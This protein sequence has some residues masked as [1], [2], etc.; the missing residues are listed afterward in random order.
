A[1]K[2]SPDTVHAEIGEI[3]AGRKPGRPSDEETILFW[4]RGLAT[5][6]IALGAAILEKAARLK[7]GTSLVYR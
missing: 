7:I 6:D 2:V 4:H 5:S 1:G 3:C